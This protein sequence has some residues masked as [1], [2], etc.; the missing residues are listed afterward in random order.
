MKEDEMAK[1]CGMHGKEEKC[2]QCSGG[3]PK[4]E[5][6]FIRAKHKWKNETKMD[7][8]ETDKTVCNSFI[9]LTVHK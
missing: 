6:P 8:T 5:R 2:M 1:V 3:K 9:W 4:G 7:F